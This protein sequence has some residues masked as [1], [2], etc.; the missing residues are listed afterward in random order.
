MNSSI[1]AISF[2]KHNVSSNDIRPEYFFFFL[3]HQSIRNKQTINIM[4]FFKPLIQS[5]QSTKI[6]KTK[7]YTL[8]TTK[9][10]RGYLVS[11]LLSVHPAFHVH[12][13]TPTVLD[14]FFPYWAQMI[15]SMRGCVSIMTFDLDLYLQGNSVMILQSVHPAFRVCSVTHTVLD[16][17]F[18]Y[19]AQMITS[20]RECVVHNDLWPWP[21]SS[22]SFSHD[23]AIC[24]SRIPCPLCNFYCPGWILS[25]LGP[26]DH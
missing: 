24:P 20:M 7:Y 6:G 14:G 10:L 22:R 25:I 21:I 5:E 15:T 13:I 19:W 8:H 18:P 17:F 12:S 26:N 16:G 1:K 3:I 4:I 11:L 9:L 23:F 2:R